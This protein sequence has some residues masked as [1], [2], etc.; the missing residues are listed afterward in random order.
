MFSLEIE[1]AEV[2]GKDVHI[3]SDFIGGDSR[4]NLSC[5]NVCVA[6]HLADRLDWHTTPECHRCGKGVP[7]EVESNR[8]RKEKRIGEDK[9]QVV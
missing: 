7:G 8:L 1:I 6:E 2:F 5:L 9:T 4:V 3:L